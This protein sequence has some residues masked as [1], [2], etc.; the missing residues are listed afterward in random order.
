MIEGSWTLT[1]LNFGS[2]R[3]A[4][5]APAEK[6]KQ[7]SAARSARQQIQPLFFIGGSIPFLWF[8]EKTL[9]PGGRRGKKEYKR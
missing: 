8:S 1:S 3:D 6:A 4:L 7:R 5:S 9:L 2:G